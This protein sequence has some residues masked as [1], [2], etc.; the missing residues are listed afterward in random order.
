ME[1]SSYKGCL[2]PR[3]VFACQLLDAWVSFCCRRGPAR[4]LCNACDG[5]TWR[6]LRLTNCNWKRLAAGTNRST[7]HNTSSG[8]LFHTAWSIGHFLLSC[9]KL[10]LTIAASA[11]ARWS[12]SPKGSSR[13]H[14][15]TPCPAQPCVVFGA[16]HPA[17]TS[18]G[19]R[20]SKQSP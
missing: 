12:P 17:W 10:P 3:A 1:L 15:A 2:Q 8:I 9:E 14:T 6:H 11:S 4:V 7:S 5:S 16:K 19:S 20:Q 18:F 13:E